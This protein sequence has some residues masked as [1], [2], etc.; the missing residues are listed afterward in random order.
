M[1]HHSVVFLKIFVGL[2]NFIESK[3]T[4]P[5]TIFFGRL[6]VYFFLYTLFYVKKKHSFAHKNK[7]KYLGK[8]H[9]SSFMFVVVYNSS[10]NFKI[11]QFFP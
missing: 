5:R 7:N 11:M 10:L 6:F 4:I 1:L 9:F 2:I 3:F 8:K